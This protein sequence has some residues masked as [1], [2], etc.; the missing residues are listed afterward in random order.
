MFPNLLGQKALHKLTEEDMARIIGVSR[1]AYQS[2]TKS[3]RFTPA[4]SA[5]PT[6]SISGRSLNTYSQ[7]TVM[8]TPAKKEPPRR[9]PRR[10]FLWKHF[11][12]K[13]ALNIFDPLVSFHKIR[14]LF[15]WLTY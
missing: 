6:A 14:E 15:H 3:G 10:L 5:V 8:S 11:Y 9:Q 2:K 7:R 13:C 1:T 4:E 12:S